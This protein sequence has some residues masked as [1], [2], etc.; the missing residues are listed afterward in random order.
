MLLREDYTTP[1]NPIG[2]KGT[3]ESGTGAG[4]AI[5]SAID[6]AIGTP[7]RGAR[8]ADYAAA[9]QAAIARGRLKVPRTGRMAAFV[10]QLAGTAGA[11]TASESALLRT[12]LIL[13]SP[14]GTVNLRISDPRRTV[15]S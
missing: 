4:A 8:A 1:L 7:R 13:S 12:R 10:V 2:I 9:A 14:D 5:A 11:M 6:D 15:S 3:G